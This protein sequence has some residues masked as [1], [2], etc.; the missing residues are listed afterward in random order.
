[1][2]GVP[3]NPASPPS[4]VGPSWGQGHPR[5]EPQRCRRG[6]DSL[7][8]HSRPRPSEW[9]DSGPCPQAVPARGASSRPGVD[10]FGQRPKVPP[11]RIIYDFPMTGE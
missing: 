9:P 8:C 10:L 3:P 5:T 11:R 2:V 1:M 6:P 7:R 4:P